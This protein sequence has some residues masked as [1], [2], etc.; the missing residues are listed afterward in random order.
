MPKMIEEMR[1]SAQPGAIHWP[2]GDQFIKGDP[3]GAPAVPIDR[4]A[5]L[6]A[7]VDT[8]VGDLGEKF[9]EARA[10]CKGQKGKFEAWCAE[11]KET[12]SRSTIYSLMGPVSEPGDGRRAP[13]KSVQV[14]DTYADGDMDH[15]DP[16][17]PQAESYEQA[18]AKALQNWGNLENRI[19]NK[20]ERQLAE[21]KTIM[22]GWTRGGWDRFDIWYKAQYALLGIKG[23]DCD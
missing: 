6:G 20:E 14:V 18:D 11:R 8:M 3:V 21:V 15:V 17:A 1:P 4:L 9:R 2:N 23:Y 5:Q 7:E 19:E 12:W 13:R 16:P 22:S 10:L